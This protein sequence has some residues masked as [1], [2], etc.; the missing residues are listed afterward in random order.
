[1][2]CKFCGCNALVD[3][4]PMCGEP[5]INEATKN[6]LDELSVKRER[7]NSRSYNLSSK[8]NQKKDRTKAFNHTLEPWSD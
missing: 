7:I 6:Y 3:V 2:I 5:Y 1:M 8:D 4:C